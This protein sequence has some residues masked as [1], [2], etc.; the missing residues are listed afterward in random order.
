M[1]TIALKNQNV[2]VN[3]KAEKKAEKK[4]SGKDRSISFRKCGCIRSICLF[5]K[6]K[7][8]CPRSQIGWDISKWKIKKKSDSRKNFKSVLLFFCI[9]KSVGT[10]LF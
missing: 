3:N 1:T 2:Y 5:I 10:C 6:R 8:L 9:E 7:N 4:V